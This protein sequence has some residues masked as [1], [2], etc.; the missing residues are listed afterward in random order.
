MTSPDSVKLFYSYSHRDEQFRVQLEAHLSTL[1]RQ[2]LI[3][4][5]H[6]REIVP[7]QEWRGIIDDSLETSKVILLLVSADFINSDYCYET[8]MKR[9]VEKHDRGEAIVVP[10][11]IRPADWQETPF[12]KIQAIP[13]DGK[14]VTLWTN[15]DE[16]WLD[17]VRGI[18]RVLTRLTTTSHSMPPSQSESSHPRILWT[19]PYRHNPFFTGREH[20]LERLRSTLVSE[21]QHS[22]RPQA[23]SGLGGIGKTQLATEYAYQYRN[24]YETV[25]WAEADSQEILI[26]SLI[27]F[28]QLLNLQ[29]KDS[30]D[31]SDK[32]PDAVTAVKN[33]LAANTG[34]LLIFDNANDLTMAQN[35]LPTRGSGHI[36][37]TTQAQ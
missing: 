12:G 8:E 28:A 29:F 5:W 20:V 13:K 2:S 14:P 31:P 10:V 11:I 34:W 24:D 32:R 6:D 36:L 27:S 19:V 3:E 23:I 22:A 25:L 16:A 33:W 7:G 37:F 26:S 18:R 21:G 35:F 1:R 4:E 17:V 15:Q 30:K 9:A